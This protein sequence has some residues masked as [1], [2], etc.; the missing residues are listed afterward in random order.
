MGAER[1]V[2]G[3]DIVPSK[4]RLSDR[5]TTPAGGRDPGRRSGEPRRLTPHGAL[6]DERLTSIEAIMWRAGQDSGLRM[7]IGNLMLLDRLP[8]RAAV[9]ARLTAA[10]ER[11]PRLKQRP[12]DPTLVRSRPAWVEDADYD[13]RHHL[14]VAAVPSPGDQRQLLDL[15][16]LLEPAPFDPNHSPWDATLIEGLAGGTGRLLPA[17]SPCAHRRHGRHV[18]RGVDARRRAGTGGVRAARHAA[19][20]PDVAAGADDQGAGAAVE[21][22]REL[23]DGSIGRRPGTVSVTLDLTRAAGDLTAR[24]AWRWTRWRWPATSIRSTRSSARVAEGSRHRQLGLP[25]GRRRGWA[26][27]APAVGAL[28]LQ[29][30]RGHLG[31][32]RPRHRALP[33]REPQR[34]ARRR[35]RRRPRGV[36]GAPRPARRPSCAW[37]C[38]P[39]ATVTARPA[40]T[41]SRPPRRGPDQRRASRSALRRGLGTAGP[42]PE[43]AGGAA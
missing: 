19:A 18:A 23:P 26:A 22:P 21:R 5:A 3:D 7:T 30:L 15:L 42:G 39:A 36:P 16:A 4:E 17:G 43:R 40:A 35:G 2:I 11:A 24:P 13:G 34:P 9:E 6:M 41:G 33:R 32:R 20:A 12:D 37:P 25:P 10:A 14:R 27:L 1:T 31:A 8:D 38:R 29:P 28:G